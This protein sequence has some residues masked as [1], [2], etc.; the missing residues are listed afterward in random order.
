MTCSTSIPGAVRPDHEVQVDFGCPK[1][2]T[3]SGSTSTTTVVAVN[4]RSAAAA[5]ADRTLSEVEEQIE[6]TFESAVRSL[7]RSLPPSFLRSSR[8]SLS[9]PASALRTAP[10]SRV[11]VA[12]WPQPGHVAT[13]LKT[14]DTLSLDSKTTHRRNDAARKTFSTPSDHLV[15]AGRGRDAA[16][17]SS[18]RC[19]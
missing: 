4:V 9:F 3:S 7:W 12:E 15:A 8:C 17:P 14:S 2:I 6:R 19:R 10:D 18:W 13:I 1:T 11:P 16:P 5:W